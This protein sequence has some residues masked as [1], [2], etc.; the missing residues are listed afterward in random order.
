MSASLKAKVQVK[1]ALAF[2]EQAG[3]LGAVVDREN[4]CILNPSRAMPGNSA[5]V[6]YLHYS[7]AHVFILSYVAKL[8]NQ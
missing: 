5:T 7:M 8:R 6:F 1:A 2:L 3:V 4:P